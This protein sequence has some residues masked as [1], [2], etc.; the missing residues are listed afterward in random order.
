MVEEKIEEMDADL[1]EGLKKKHIY[2]LSQMLL[3]GKMRP[4]I[5]DE[6]KKLDESYESLIEKGRSDIEKMRL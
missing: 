3:T 6:F 2:K 4:F 1:S 5:D